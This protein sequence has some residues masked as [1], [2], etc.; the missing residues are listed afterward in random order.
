MLD[1]PVAP[2]ALIAAAAS[3]HNHLALGRAVDTPTLR[4]AMSNAFGGSDA[5]GAWDWKTSYDACE[6]AT[7]LFLRRFGPGMRG[8]AGS[9]TALLAM[10]AR[11][12]QL[13]SDFRNLAAWWCRNSRSLTFR[14]LY[15]FA[16]HPAAQKMSSEAMNRRAS[17]RGRMVRPNG[18]A[19]V[20]RSFHSDQ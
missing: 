20:Q 6:A 1:S 19:L 14:I 2:A 3:L 17:S 7:V 12:S 4:A 15:P 5:E 11:L 8:C 10:L 9:P 18:P 16:G 13:D